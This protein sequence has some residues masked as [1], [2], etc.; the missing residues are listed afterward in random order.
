MKRGGSCGPTSEE[1]EGLGAEE[2]DFLAPGGEGGEL[3]LLRGLQ[4]AVVVAVH[5]VLQ[6]PV[7][8][9]RQAQITDGADSC[10]GCGNG[11]RH[12]GN[13]RWGCFVN[14]RPGAVPNW[15][16]VVCR[17]AEAEFAVEER[18]CW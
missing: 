5:E 12:G 18:R 9:G 6:M 2:G 17:K 16:R 14:E 13:R 1:L 8:L 11:G 10:L 15:L 4:E 7:C 3:L